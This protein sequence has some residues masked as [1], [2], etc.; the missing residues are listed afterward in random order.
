MS[1]RTDRLSYLGYR[2]GAAVANA[3]PVPVAS[4]LAAG[5]GAG[6]S[7]AL[8]GRRTMLARH[9]RRVYGDGLSEAQLDAKV[10]QAFDSYAKYWLESFR[11][12][13]TGHDALEAG[14]SWEGVARV[15]EALAAG[16]GVIMAMPHLGGWD[17]GAAWLASAG[18]PATV[19]VE[20]LEPRELFEWFVSLREAMGLTVVPHG[21]EAGTAVLR[22]LR[23]NEIV[24]LV[25][26]R[27]LA[28]NGIEVEFFGERTTLPAGPA[29]LALRTGAVL[30]P[31]AIYF[32]ERGHHGVVRPPVDTSRSGSFRDDVGR[33]MQAFAHE[34]EHLIRRAPEQ[35]HLMQP[36]WPS[37]YELIAAAPTSP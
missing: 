12:G 24:G 9:L 13:S 4:V 32:A 19:V 29:T 16:N 20:A 33:V 15:D 27:D 18:F 31:C 5:A 11:L 23:A 2:V 26:D 34:L 1:A 37:D 30:L 7:R 8:K 28:R 25:A 35:W 6:F 3:L 36:N 17:F 10:A 21:P 14:M 22:A